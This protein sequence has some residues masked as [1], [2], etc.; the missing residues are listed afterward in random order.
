MELA[1]A[2]AGLMIWWGLVCVSDSIDKIA[3]LFSDV[4]VT[5]T[6]TARLKIIDDGERGEVEG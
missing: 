4:Q 5:Q 2:F 1:V 6:T 3:V